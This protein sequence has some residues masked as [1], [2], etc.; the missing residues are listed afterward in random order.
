[1]PPL[2]TLNPSPKP[3]E[4]R[5]SSENSKKKAIYNPVICLNLVEKRN[6]EASI[7]EASYKLAVLCYT[8]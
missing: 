2:V 1:M 5:A 6:D 3:K 4:T 7:L 8:H